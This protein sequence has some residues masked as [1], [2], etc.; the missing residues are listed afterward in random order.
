MILVFRGK[1]FGDLHVLGKSDIL[2]QRALWILF[3]A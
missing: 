1:D 2:Y 3:A